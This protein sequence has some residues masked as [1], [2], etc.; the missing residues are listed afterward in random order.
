MRLYEKL[1]GK[2]IPVARLKRMQRHY[3]ELLWRKEQEI[4]A[5]KADKQ[6]LLRHGLTQA[7]KRHELLEHSKKVIAINRELN[8]MVKKERVLGNALKTNKV[9][10]NKRRK[11]IRKR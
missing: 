7:E 9:T 8:E 6:L 11:K 10:Q 4:E 1:F 3:Q 5:L 2:K